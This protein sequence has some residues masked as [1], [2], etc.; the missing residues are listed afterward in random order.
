MGQPP[1][2][3][4]IEIAAR[5]DEVWAALSHVPSMKKRSPEL[6]MMRLTGKPKVGRRGLNI[7]RRK[8]FAWPTTSRITRWKP[9]ANDSG[10]GS[11]AFY[12]WPTDVEWS[13]DLEPTSTGTRVVE[14][15]TALPHPSL[16]VRLTAKWAL[17][18]ADN[19]DVELLAG[20]NATLAALKADVEG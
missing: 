15:R 19:H 7:N 11:F 6:V 2:E 5:P 4:E 16:T 12:V 14:R 3:A 13:Y 18:G 9:P 10:H 1:L 17:G 20:M 8:G